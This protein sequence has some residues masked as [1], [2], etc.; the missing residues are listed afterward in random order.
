VGGVSP[1]NRGA[2]L[3]GHAEKSWLNRT[4]PVKLT[5]K[6][7]DR[8]KRGKEPNLGGTEEFVPKLK[9]SGI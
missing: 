5:Y 9:E 8:K 6:R 4:R 1:H 3:R 2:I 7:K